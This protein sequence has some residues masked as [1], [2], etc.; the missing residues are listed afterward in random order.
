MVTNMPNKIEAAV[1]EDADNAFRS[2]A[3]FTNH[4][5]AAA[6]ADMIR[7]SF[8]E[9]NPEGTIRTCRA[10]IIMAKQTLF[11]TANLLNNIIKQLAEHEQRMSQQKQQKIMDQEKG[12]N[13][14]L[15]SVMDLMGA[16]KED[17]E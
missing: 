11:E 12:A 13:Q 16:K 1:Q 6:A 7:L 3:V 17:L 2:P 14:Q 4:I 10:T 5:V 15:P 8:L 9:K